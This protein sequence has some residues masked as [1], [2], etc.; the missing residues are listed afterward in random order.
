[1]NGNTVQ[2]LDTL[3]IHV[4]NFGKN[5]AVDLQSFG[6][7]FVGQLPKYD[8]LTS[9]NFDDSTQKRIRGIKTYL[10][11]HE[12]KF[13]E[14]DPAIEEYQLVSLN[15]VRALIKLCKSPEAKDIKLLYDASMVDIICGS[16]AKL[17]CEQV[18]RSPQYNRLWQGIDECLKKEESELV[19]DMY[20]PKPIKD[21][22]NKLLL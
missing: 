15:E 6:M 10:D 17:K 11:L 2:Y 21:Y 7:L 16:V 3:L 12:D 22:L 14:N 9:T 19:T 8:E 13:D 1:M 4:E 18:Y 5:I 20:I